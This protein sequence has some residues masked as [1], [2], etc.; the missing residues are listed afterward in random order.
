MAAGVVGRSREPR[1]QG[2]NMKRTYLSIV[3]AGALAIGASGTAAAAPASSGAGPEPAAALPQ[4]VLEGTYPWGIALA[5]DR[6]GKRHVVA[7]RR[8]GDLWY[9]TDRSGSWASERILTGSK[10][11]WVWGKPSLALDGNSRIHIAVVK[12]YPFDTPGGTNGIWYVTDK[13]RA[14]GDFGEPVRITGDSTTDPS[15]R[16]VGNVRYLAYATQPIPGDRS[17]PLYFRTDRSGKW[18]RVRVAYRG[19]DPALRVDRKGRARIVFG[20]AKGVRYTQAGTKTG[21]FT[22]PKIISRGKHPSDAPSL[23]LNPA[24]QPN[25]AWP[26]TKGG[27]R[28]WYARRGKSGWSTPRAIGGGRVTEISM[29]AKS[30]PH[31]AIGSRKII[32]KWRTASGWR[33]R[34]ITGS[35]VSRYA[36]EDVGIRSFGKRASIAWAPGGTGQGVWVVRD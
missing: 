27:Y 36:M 11:D 19:F 14:R 26:S 24:G 31:V 32:H 23:V 30:R 28:I 3:I 2:G 16:V 29:D 15:L 6:G 25:V 1:G 20:T 21:N 18:N 13:G 8:N 7:G 5:V 12:D 34:A 17:W 9:A 10:D 22:K 4:Q 35:A 33:R